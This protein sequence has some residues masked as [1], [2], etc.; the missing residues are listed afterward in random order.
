MVMMA[1]PGDVFVRTSL[2]V[3]GKTRHHPRVEI[4]G[5]RVEIRPA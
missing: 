2:G 1:L 4:A 3:E 5:G